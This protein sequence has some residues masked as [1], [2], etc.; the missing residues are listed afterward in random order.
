MI[1]RI[2]LNSLPDLARDTLVALA[3]GF[4]QLLAGWVILG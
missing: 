3:P 2:V 1:S 4:C